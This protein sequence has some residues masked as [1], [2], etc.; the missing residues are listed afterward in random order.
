MKVQANI[1]LIETL[2][3]I[4]IFSGEKFQ[5]GLGLEPATYGN[6]A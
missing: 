1:F 5:V 6:T 4:N 2:A 3:Y